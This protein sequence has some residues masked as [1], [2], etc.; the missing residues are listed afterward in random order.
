MDRESSG[1]AEMKARTEDLA[2]DEARMKRT[3]GQNQAVTNAAILVF[4]LGMLFP[5]RCCISR[6]RWIFWG[7]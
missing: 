3:A 6:A 7:S 5:L 4:S 1:L 2:Q